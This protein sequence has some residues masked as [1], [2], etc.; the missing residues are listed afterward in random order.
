MIFQAPKGYKALIC[1]LH[2]QY[3]NSTT[4]LSEYDARRT[5]RKW[6][7]RKIEISKFA[8]DIF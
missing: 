4:K 7:F 2:L 3:G 8:A 1:E 5:R 6:R